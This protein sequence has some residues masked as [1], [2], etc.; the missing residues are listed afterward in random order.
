MHY[1]SCSGGPGVDLKK[2]TPGLAMLNLCFCIR[3]DLWVTWCGL[4]RLG[5]EMS[6][7][8]FSC[9][10]GSGV[11]PT[12]STSRHVMMNSCF[13][14]RVDLWV[15]YC[16]LV[17][18]RHKMLTY[19][20]LCLA[21]PG[22]APTKSTLGHCSQENLIDCVKLGRTLSREVSTDAFLFKAIKGT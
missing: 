10:G 9:S 16:I 6:T 22:V 17:H 14:I 15:T 20:L 7:L 19:Y 1:F 21:G 13:C 12:K 3:C 18:L 4:V 11:G 2:R 5:R 8:Y